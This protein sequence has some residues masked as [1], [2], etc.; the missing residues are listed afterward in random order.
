MTA[1]MGRIMRRSY[2][3]VSKV[4]LRQQRATSGTVDR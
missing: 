4:L 3:G 2:A 1:Q